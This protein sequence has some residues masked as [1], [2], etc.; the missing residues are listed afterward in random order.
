VSGCFAFG[1]L[2]RLLVA[3]GWSDC[4]AE[5]RCLEGVIQDSGSTPSGEQPEGLLCF[6]VHSISGELMGELSAEE[7]LRRYRKLR[8]L[9]ADGSM[10]GEVFHLKHM[11]LLREMGVSVDTRTQAAGRSHSPSRNRPSV[12]LIGARLDRY[13]SGPAEA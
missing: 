9:H 6:Q 5:E 13:G 12:S 8:D 2:E 4:S 10:S 11:A 1:F 7:A 3:V